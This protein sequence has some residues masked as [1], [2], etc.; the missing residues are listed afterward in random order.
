[1]AEP[2]STT[3]HTGDQFYWS[4]NAFQ[5]FAIQPG[6]IFVTWQRAAA[7]SSTTLPAYTNVLGTADFA[8]NGAGIYLLYTARYI[9]SS[10]AVKTPQR[11]YWTESSFQNSGHPV[12]VPST[13]VSAINVIYNNSFPMRV[14]T[15]YVDPT[16]AQPVEST[17]MYRETRTLW[18]DNTRGVN[19]QILAYIAEGR[20][21]VELLG[22]PNAGAGT[23]E[24][25]GFEIVD[26]FKQPTPADVTINLGDRLT[27]YQ[28]GSDDW[29]LTPA[30]LL[31]EQSFYYSQESQGGLWRSLYAVRETIHINDFEVYWLVTGVA[32]LKWPVLFDRY[33]LVWPADP[34]PLH[35]LPAPPGGH[36]R[37]S[38][39]DRHSVALF[40]G[41][42]NRLPGPRC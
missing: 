2:F 7:Y 27:A 6:P 42:H 16:Q 34:L 12:D 40:R 5:V 25:L 19:G 33:R 23:R 32:G 20:V 39:T 21:F 8:T 28:D 41:P 24:F 31:G 13:R 4:T 35:L 37:G 11:I 14:A 29:D 38:R 3:G 10:S 1:M 15:P 30:P 26:V 9:I 36:R 18:F 17:N 22:P